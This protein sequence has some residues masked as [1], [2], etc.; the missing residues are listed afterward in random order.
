MNNGKGREESTDIVDE[1]VKY[2][3]RVYS[4][5]YRRDSV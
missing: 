1:G 5:L 4:D 2:V 3:Q